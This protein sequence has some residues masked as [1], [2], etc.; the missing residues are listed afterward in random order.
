ELLH[1]WSEKRL[2]FDNSITKYLNWGL[3]FRF[4][5]A[6]TDLVGVDLSGSNLSNVNLLGVNILGE[7]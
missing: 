5:L 7:V 6:N 4:N 3:T 1:L 2:K